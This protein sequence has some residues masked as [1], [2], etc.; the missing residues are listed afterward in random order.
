MHVLLV[1]VL[2]K[3]NEDNVII[4]FKLEN[5]HLKPT[6]NGKTKIYRVF[7]NSKEYRKGLID[8]AVIIKINNSVVENYSA[9]SI[10]DKLNSVKMPFTLTLDYT[11][12]AHSTQHITHLKIH[13]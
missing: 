11:V 10:A 8:G 12:K 6:E 1:C 7:Y 5:V 2:C 4:D 9:Q 3:Q 13:C